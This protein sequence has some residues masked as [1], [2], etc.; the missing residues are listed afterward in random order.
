MLSGLIR[1]VAG[2]DYQNTLSAMGRQYYFKD[3]LCRQDW[4]LPA[5][6]AAT[7]SLL[8]RSNHNFSVNEV[9]AIELSGLHIVAS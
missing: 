3:E 8:E 9:A 5:N 6:N 1:G 2:V 7:T 4:W